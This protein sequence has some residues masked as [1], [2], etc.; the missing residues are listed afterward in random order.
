MYR[1]NQ[2]LEIKQGRPA[3]SFFDLGSHMSLFS[4]FSF[5]F[6]VYATSWALVS[7]GQAVAF[8]FLLSFYDVSLRWEGSKQEI[9]QT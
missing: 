6:L 8:F 1:T 3:F 2:G 7:L 4:Y 5:V 9:T